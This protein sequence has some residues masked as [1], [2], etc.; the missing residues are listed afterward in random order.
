ME[1]IKVFQYELL[2]VYFSE[3]IEHLTAKI[4]IYLSRCVWDVT[5]ITKS[6]L[7][8]KEVQPGE[9]TM[10]FSTALI[11]TDN[12]SDDDTKNSVVFILFKH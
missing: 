7:M 5:W 4:Y 1:Y 6:W 10:T 12:L 11:I 3:Y 2:S 8:N 9:V